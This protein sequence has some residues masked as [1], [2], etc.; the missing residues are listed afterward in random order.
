MGAH[1]I[2]VVDR[3][4][5]SSS[6]VV[7]NAP[8]LPARPRLL[9]PVTVAVLLILV[10]GGVLV[11]LYT[12]LLWFRETGFSKVFSTVLRTKLLLFVIF[13]LL[14]AVAIGVNLALAYRMRP[15]FRPM[16]L[17]QQN[18]EKYRLAVERFMVPVIDRGERGVRDLRGDRGGGAVGDLAAVAQRAVVR[19]RPTRSSARTCRSTCS[20]TRCCGSSSAS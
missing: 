10:F 3:L 12:D 18:L 15:P 9:V 6:M 19:D 4:W 1:E 13:G 5:L 8:S 14:M 20:P 2:I 11:S 17:E 16:S 7:R